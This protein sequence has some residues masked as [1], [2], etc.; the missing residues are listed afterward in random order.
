[1]NIT[2]VVPRTEAFKTFATAAE[3]CRA[4]DKAAP[5]ADTRDGFVETRADD[6]SVQRAMF[7]RGQAPNDGAFRYILEERN[8]QGKLQRIEYATCTPEVA[9]VRPVGVRGVRVVVDASG[10]YSG[11]GI[12]DKSDDPALALVYQ[13]TP[14]EARTAG[15][16]LAAQFARDWSPATGPPPL[17][18][19]VETTPSGLQYI[20]AKVGDG[21]MPAPG[22]KVTVH[23]TGW[24]TDG[25][26]FDSSR[27]RDEPFEFPIGQGQV[28]KGW[29]EGVAS[30]RV[31]GQRRLIIPPELGYGAGGAGGV[32]PPNATL[33][34]DVELLGV[35]QG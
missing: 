32:I 15:D 35:A 29:D 17:D 7:A 14:A 24:L 33:V 31:G 4:S 28:I 34:F 10:Q 8:S 13:L 16:Q 12:Q 21:P 1:M 9:G 11:V 23:Y 26:K 3:G 2:S 20:D 25:T 5:D 6:G 27:D 19:K 30:M 18:G 22:Q